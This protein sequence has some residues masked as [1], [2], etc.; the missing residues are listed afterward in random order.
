MERILVSSSAIT[1][2]PDSCS[3]DEDSDDEIGRM[4]YNCS[5]TAK[6]RARAATS[7]TEKN[8]CSYE[9]CHKYVQNN[10]VCM[11]HGATFMTANQA[12]KRGLCR[13]Y[14]EDTTKDTQPSQLKSGGVSCGVKRRCNMSHEDEFCSRFR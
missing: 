2:K 13:K 9:G 10:G 14:P 6:A 12:R 1:N 8:I 3:S 11:K 4:V 7:L 5:E